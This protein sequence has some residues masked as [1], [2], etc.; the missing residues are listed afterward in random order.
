MS[1]S[2]L[3]NKK[4]LAILLLAL[5][6]CTVQNAVA[7]K[8]DGNFTGLPDDRVEYY[9]FMETPGLESFDNG[10]LDA[11]NKFYSGYTDSDTQ[12]I[13]ELVSLSAGHISPWIIVKFD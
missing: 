10:V 8:T 1:T 7:S 2:V 9:R 4:C 5:S 13:S 11:C 3:H 12:D 6:Y